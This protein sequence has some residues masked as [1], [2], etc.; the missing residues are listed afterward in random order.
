M[1]TLRT[2]SSDACFQLLTNC[3]KL[4]SVKYFWPPLF[5]FV[6][7]CHHYITAAFFTAVA[8]FCATA[9]AFLRS[10]RV[11]HCRRS[12][13]CIRRE[14]C[15]CSSCCSAE[16]GSSSEPSMLP[17]VNQCSS[18]KCGFLWGKAANI[19][20]HIKRAGSLSG[21]EIV[22][23]NKLVAWV[24]CSL[25]RPLF[26]SSMECDLVLHQIWK[27]RNEID[28]HEMGRCQTLHKCSAPGPPF[29][30]SASVPHAALKSERTSNRG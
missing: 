30:W 29:W 5:L 21:K 10:L 7:S 19:R 4:V 20:T 1:R 14:S 25:E 28:H 17:Q 23:K 2:S 6:P 8:V 16:Q 15:L 24:A 18:P 27:L 26:F 9:A 12:A 13:W 3:W 11:P 22:L